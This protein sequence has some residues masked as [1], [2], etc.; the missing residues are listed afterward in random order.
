MNLNLALQQQRI[1]SRTTLP[2]KCEKGFEAYEN[3]TNFDWLFVPELES[4]KYVKGGNIAKLSGGTV[5]I[6]IA[7]MD[8][9]QQSTPSSS[10]RLTQLQEALDQLTTQFYFSLRYIASHH[11]PAQIPGQFTQPNPDLP[12]HSP[13]EFASAQAELAK[14]I[15]IKMKQIELLIASLPGV[16]RG[17]EEQLERVKELE[18]LLRQK[19]KERVEEGQKREEVLQRLG[20]VVTG[21]RRF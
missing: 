15:V 9:P 3:G 4:R 13:Q 17:E 19:E 21:L 10:D 14:D 20:N 5:R 2:K 12:S 11:S 8:P 16:G 1:N 6:L 7:L 18:E